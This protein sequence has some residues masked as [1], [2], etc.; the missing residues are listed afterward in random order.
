[1]FLLYM[2]PLCRKLMQ[3]YHLHLSETQLVDKRMQRS[4][5]KWKHGFCITIKASAPGSVCLAQSGLTR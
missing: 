1:M 2:L 5:K 3:M 4:A